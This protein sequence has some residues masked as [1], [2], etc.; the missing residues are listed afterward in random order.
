MPLDATDVADLIAAEYERLLRRP[1]DADAFAA[2]LREGYASRRKAEPN[3][4]VWLA[5]LAP[6]GKNGQ[7]VRLDEFVV[8]VG[9]LVNE[10]ADACTALGLNLHATRDEDHGVVVYGLERGGLVGFVEMKET[11]DSR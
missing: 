7:R 2:V 5:D 1:L 4:P 8:D 11:D 9:R 3:R 6:T 10:H